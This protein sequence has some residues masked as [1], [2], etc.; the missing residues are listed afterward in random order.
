MDHWRI[1]AEEAYKG[2]A[3]VTDNKNFRGEQMPKFD[4]L[5]EKI[6]EAWKAAVKV[7]I[8]YGVKTNFNGLQWNIPA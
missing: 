6:Q 3:N 1:I 4:E 5:P 7:A 2:Y 8:M